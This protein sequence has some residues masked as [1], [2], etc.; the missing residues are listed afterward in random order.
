MKQ[1]IYTLGLGI[2]SVIFLGALLKINH[3]PGGGQLL[4]LGVVTL[5]MVF[6]PLALGNHYT[7]EGGK[8]I[9]CCI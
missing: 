6:L 5:V 7:A 2:T 8:R 3:W 4:V 9:C 1:K